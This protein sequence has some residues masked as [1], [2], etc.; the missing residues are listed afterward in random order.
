[1]KTKNLLII[2]T[3]FIVGN[4]SFAQEATWSI[5]MKGNIL[6]QKITPAGTLVVTTTTAMYGIDPAK[7]TITWEQS[8]LA[9]IPESEYEIIPNTSFVAIVKTT[10]KT[11]QFDWTEHIVLDAISGKILC[12]TKQNDIGAVF[13]RYILY[14]SGHIL[15]YGMGSKLSTSFTLFDITTGQKVWSRSDLFGKALFGFAKVNPNIIECNSDAFVFATDDEMKSMI[16]K[17]DIKTGDVI[18]KEN[19]P[20]PKG[21]VRLTGKPP[22]LFG[23]ASQGMAYYQKESNIMGFNLADGKQAW[24]DFIKLPDAVDKIIY[25]KEGFIFCTSGSMH[26][27]DYKTGAPKWLDKK[28][29]KLGEPMIQYNYCSE[30]IVVAMGSTP[31]NS[32]INIADIEKGVFV[33]SK[34]VKVLGTVQEIRVIDKGVLYRTPNEINIVDVNSGKE[35]LPKSIKATGSDV[36]ITANKGDMMYVFST[37]N[38]T[39]YQLDTKQGSYKEIVKDVKFDDKEK[40]TS[41]EIRDNGI[42]VSSAQNMTLFDFTGKLKYHSYF[43][44]PENS[45]LMKVLGGA[46]AVL[47]AMYTMQAAMMTAATG[48]IAASAS[49]S[50]DKATQEVGKGMA[51]ASDYYAGA[52]GQAANMSKMGMDVIR[53][54]FTAS[55][56]ANNYY[57]MLSKVEKSVKLLKINKADGQKMGEIDFKK[58]K[59]PNYD[60]DDISNQLYYRTNANKLSC[61]K[62]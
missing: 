56:S 29:I 60:I 9:N 46:T 59:E 6:W 41:I 16:F 54:R 14:N 24:K 50:N 19:V 12:N 15:I 17:V 48:A 4:T 20:N 31:D 45:K 8:S 40:A 22:R 7:G 43:P 52:T 28:G 23:S 61:Y 35:I 49:Q 3:L 47:G 38:N 53:K 36:L 62:F 2:I 25:D 5:D 18:W 34:S 10:K 37:D 55:A 44:A 11:P 30:G 26:M 39:L 51:G 32:F 21:M 27:Y 58:D 13:N 1:M 42:L 33:G 57:F